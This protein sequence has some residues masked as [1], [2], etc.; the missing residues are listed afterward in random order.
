MFHSDQT[1]IALSP[2]ITKK[3]DEVGRKEAIVGGKKVFKIHHFN[4]TFTRDKV[5]KKW[6]R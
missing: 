3:C 1:A 4:E 5:G 6:T 2:V